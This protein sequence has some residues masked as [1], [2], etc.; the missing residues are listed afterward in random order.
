MRQPKEYKVI[1]V[2]YCKPLPPPIRHIQRRVGSLISPKSEVQ[3]LDTLRSPSW[4]SIGRIPYRLYQRPSQVLEVA[5]LKLSRPVI[6]N[7]KFWVMKD[8][9]VKESWIKEFSIGLLAPRG[10]EKDVAQSLRGSNLY[11]IRSFVQAFC[12][13]INGDILLQLNYKSRVLVSYDPKNGIFKQLL[14]RGMPNWFQ[15]L[16]M[17]VI[18]LSSTHRN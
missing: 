7:L 8:Y 12:L 10:F 11:C 1:T 18:L 14:F 17:R 2:V 5:F 13:L 15:V 4:R 6:A 3:L 16:F 9:D